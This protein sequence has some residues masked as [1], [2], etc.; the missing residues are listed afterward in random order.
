MKIGQFA[1]DLDA[2]NQ[3]EIFYIPFTNNGSANLNVNGSVTPVVFTLDIP[4]DKFAI[5]RIDYLISTNDVL[6]IKKFGSLNALANGLLFEIN[7][8]HNF[9]T[10]A[11]VMLFASDSTLDSVKITGTVATIIN[12]NWSPLDVFHHALVA[13]KNNLKLT[14]R[15]DL[16]TLPFLQFAVSG[17]KIESN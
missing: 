9:K 12:G 5:T 16:S 14:V 17:I 6:D 1:T 3:E 10:N 11:D 7:G 2:L 15:D 13:D 8:T 4:M